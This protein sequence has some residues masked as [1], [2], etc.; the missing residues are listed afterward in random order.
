MERPLG[1]V[2]RT[3]LHQSMSPVLLDHTSSDIGHM[4]EHESLCGWGSMVS[5]L[6]LDLCLFLAQT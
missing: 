4:V 5:V 1:V 6:S 3:E 2:S